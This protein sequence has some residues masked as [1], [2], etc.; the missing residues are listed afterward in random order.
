[1]ISIIAAYSK[2]RVIGNNGKIPWC[3]REDMQHFKLLTTGNI[4]IMGRKTFEEIGHPL[5]DRYTII[6]STLKKLNFPDADTA[7]TFEEAII[8]AQK[9]AESE[10]FFYKKD[11]YIC[12]GQQV[13]EEGIAIADRMFITEIDVELTGDK[14]F[15]KFDENHFSIF[16]E[17]R[18]QNK[19]YSFSFIEY[20]RK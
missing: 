9:I 1:M 13:Y 2:N 8:K 16:S 10:G 18:F 5:P 4:L 15:P 19:E 11:I 12:G 17:E 6:I 20:R 3:I 7:V 14:Y